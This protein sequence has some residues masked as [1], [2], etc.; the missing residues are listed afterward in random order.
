MRRE[1]GQKFSLNDNSSS[2][3]VATTKLGTD[4]APVRDVV[5]RKNGAIIL[6]GERAAVQNASGPISGSSFEMQQRNLDKKRR[7]INRDVTP[8]MAV[9]PR[10]V[11]ELQVSGVSASQQPI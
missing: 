11:R 10:L 5:L 6:F 1:G 8:K 7:L 9:A 3:D 4:V 2:G